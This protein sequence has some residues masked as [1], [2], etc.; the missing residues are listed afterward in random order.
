MSAIDK[1]YTEHP[2]FGSRKI[3]AL[4]RKQAEWRH[5]DRKRIARLMRVMGI[6]AIYP[7]PRT[8]QSDASHPKFPY[9]LKGLEI[10][11]PNRVWCSDI[12]YIPTEKGFVYLSAI[13]D[14]YSRYVLSWEVSNS[15]E[16]SFCVS[17][18]EQ[19]LVRYGRPDIF[20]SDQGCQY[21]SE[22]FTGILEKHGV[23]IS[24]DGRGR[25]MDNI[26]IERLWRS[27][28]YEEVYLKSYKTLPEARTALRDYFEFYN[29]GRPHQSLK[30][31]TP[32][33]VHFPDGGEGGPQKAGAIF[34]NFAA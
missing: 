9:L 7:K 34:L 27:L 23:R 22:I 16:S 24:M 5:V 17:A 33:E 25:C 10:G 11:A 3:A 14:W 19:A 30:Y 8:S 31:R 21:T 15:L 6:E 12:T 4:L 32:Y 28:K 13:M 18:L 26:F 2:Y 1:V 20:N 29:N